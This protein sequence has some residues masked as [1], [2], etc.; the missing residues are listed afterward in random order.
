MI[1]IY[2]HLGL[3]DHIICNGLVR[4]YAE[5]QKVILPAKWWN[6][7]AVSLMYSDNPDIEVIKVPSDDEAIQLFN[8]YQGTETD[9]LQITWNWAIG[10]ETGIQF[11]EWFYKGYDIPFNYRWDKF[12]CPRFLDEEDALFNKY[13][14]AE[15]YIFVHDDPSRGLTIDRD[16]IKSDLQI[17]KPDRSLTDNIFAYY[18]LIEQAQEVHCMN[19]CFALLTDSLFHGKPNCYAHKYSRNDS[20]STFRNFKVIE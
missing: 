14:P 8:G 16:K 4:H 20:F 13:H 17:I 12:K 6:Y 15:K 7:P 10:S 9:T 5:K 1:Y 2:H 18:K 19:S 11:D 3:G